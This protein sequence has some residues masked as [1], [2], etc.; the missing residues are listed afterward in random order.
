MSAYETYKQAMTQFREQVVSEICA[1]ASPNPNAT[2]LGN[3]CFS[4]KASLL[5]SA[6]ILDPFYYDYM[7][8]YKLVEEKAQTQTPETFLNTLNRI[9]ETGKLGDNRFNPEV[10]ESLKKILEVA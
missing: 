5:G 6:L 1:T 9:I 10:I 7:A 8:Q 3:G 4:V 2:P